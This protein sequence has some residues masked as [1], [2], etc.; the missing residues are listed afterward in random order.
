[1]A[2]MVVMQKLDLH[3]R[4]VD[5]GRT[6]ALA[7]FARDAKLHGAVKLVRR[8]RIP[9]QLTR[10]GKPQRVGAG[11]R[12]FSLIARDA[13]RRA[14]RARVELA[15]MSVVVAHLDRGGKTA[16]DVVLADF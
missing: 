3:G 1:M 4:H 10:D 13:V 12:E 15:T 7:A 11:A 14:H 5:S 9:A 16:P 8:Q 6:F 2:A